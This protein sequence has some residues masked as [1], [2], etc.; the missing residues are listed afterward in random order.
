M[1]G[2]ACIVSIWTDRSSVQV[3]VDGCA[4]TGV[5]ER[6]ESALEL[7]IRAQGTHITVDL[8]RM[9]GPD[10]AVLE[11]LAAVCHRQWGRRGC[12]HVEGI[13]ARL[14]SAPEVAAFPEL[15]GD[16]GRTG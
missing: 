3:S 4:D 15:F 1:F 6:L 10:A 13:G 11:L 2:Q 12:L 7:I 16:L 14:A 9:E 8:S 5:C